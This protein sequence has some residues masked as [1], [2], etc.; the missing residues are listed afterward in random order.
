MPPAFGL[1]L[2]GI[3]GGQ[4]LMD[5]VA[6]FGFGLVGI[7]LRR[8]DWSRP[9]FLIGF[10]L[11]NPA[12]TYANQ[13]VQIASFRFRKSFEEGMDYLLSPIVIALLVITIVS[14]VIGWRQ[15]RNIRSEGD[16]PSGSKRAPMVF[17][18]A[19]LLTSRL[20]SWTHR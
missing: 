5:L 16:V 3:L 7:M 17:L 8:F 11:S 2:V 13:A 4:S 20:P 10:V 19:V 1:S 15:A 14:V 18:L 6:L 9:A 12:E